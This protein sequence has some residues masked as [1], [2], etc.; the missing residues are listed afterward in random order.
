MASLGTFGSFTQARLGIYAAQQGLS[1]T[2]NNIANINTR[3]YTRQRLDQTSMYA[4]TCDRYASPELNIGFGVHCTG[5][6]QLRDP[7]LDIR[8][9]SKIADMG[10]MNAKLGALQNIES[11][12]DEVGKG[13]D[14]FGIVEQQLND[15]LNTLQQLS[16]KTGQSDYE[17]QV[18]SAAEGLLKKMNS[19]A[20]QL[21]EVEHTTQQD[22]KQNVESVNKILDSIRKLNSDI[23][24]S[25]IH[26]D[27]AL[28]L[29]DERNLLIDQL[30]E[31]MRIDVTYEAEDIGAGQT[32]EKLVIKLGNMNPDKDKH[33]DETIL[34]D[35][36]YGTQISCEPEKNPNY[37]VADPTSKKYISIAGNPTDNLEEAKQ[38]FNGNYNIMISK[39]KAAN[40]DVLKDAM[41]QE[42]TDV[43]LL[44]NDLYGVLQAQREFLTESGEF[45][46]QN[47][48]DRDM[49]AKTKRGLPYYRKAL[50]LLANQIAT[51]FNNANHNFMRNE[52]GEFYT[53]GGQVIKLE[54]MTGLSAEEKDLLKNPNEMNLQ[55]KLQIAQKAD[56]ELKGRNLFSNKGD[57]DEADGI[58]A[59]NIS[60]A[61]SWAEDPH[62][63]SSFMT[64]TGFDSPASTDNSNIQHMIT[65]FNKELDYSPQSVEPDAVEKVMFRGSFQEMWTNIGTVLGN[66]MMVTGTM[67]NTYESAA[68]NLDKQRDGVSSV[69]LNDEAMNLMQY[70]KSYNAACRL[71]TTLDSVLDK[72]I[73]GTAL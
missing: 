19:Y 58:T 61:K 2:G 11:I 26:G 62:I 69:D 51:Q 70:S 39:P 6:S 59:S 8:Y 65:L 1:I 56:L 36:I 48:I 34:I 71:M 37:D 44:D 5:V 43:E 73:N 33:S 9:R 50:D 23:R 27:K 32:V 14:G 49:N 35:G 40:G 30:S 17:I 45:S 66:D 46:V 47:D 41:G 16:D 31:Y 57:G 15:L 63:E 64:P 54:D 3:G 13:E 29:R 72:L 18:R 7:Y 60:I 68:I 25:E 38:N 12:L 4:G 24:K 28:E 67:L 22:M 21:E 53:T 55:Q 20:A 42:M 10:S 52:K